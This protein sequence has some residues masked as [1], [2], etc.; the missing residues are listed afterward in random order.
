[1]EFLKRKDFKAL[2]R[3]QVQQIIKEMN[4]D[5]EKAITVMKVKK[6]DGSFASVRVWRVPA[7]DQT[8]IDLGMDDD[9][10]SSEIPF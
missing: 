2:S 6:D 5:P 3:P 1:M 7:F 9:N 10:V 8:E 4:E